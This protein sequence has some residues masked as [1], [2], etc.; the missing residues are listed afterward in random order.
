MNLFTFSFA[1]WIEY[2][3]DE[4]ES[5]LSRKILSAFLFC[6]PNGGF[7]IVVIFCFLCKNN[8]LSSKCPIS[9][10][11]GNIVLFSLRLSILYFSIFKALQSMS[12][13]KTYLAFKKA[14]AIDNLPVPAPKSTIS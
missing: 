12:T 6:T 2:I 14:Q 9:A 4:K 5:A 1:K 3:T 13:L 10:H 8:L 7:I 11:I